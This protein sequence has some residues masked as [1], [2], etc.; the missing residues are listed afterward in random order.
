MLLLRV[1]QPRLKI[2]NGPSFNLALDGVVIV[3][4]FEKRYVVSEE[5][6]RKI[7]FSINRYTGTFNHR[8]MGRNR[9]GMVMFMGARGSFLDDGTFEI[10][11]QFA[12]GKS[13]FAKVVGGPRFQM[14]AFADFRK[15]LRMLALAD[16]SR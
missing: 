10:T 3:S 4:A 13:M 7:A 11:L 15:P 8:K 12:T 1:R 14:Y 9:R 5:I 16:S 2:V 6:G